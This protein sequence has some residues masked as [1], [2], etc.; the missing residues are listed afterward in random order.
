MRQIS[1]WLTSGMGRRRFKGENGHLVILS[2]NRD[3]NRQE[4]IVWYSCIGIIL[5]K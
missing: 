1:M 2:R 5:I 3:L 4:D